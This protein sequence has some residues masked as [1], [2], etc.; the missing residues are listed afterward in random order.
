MFTRIIAYSFHRPMIWVLIGKGFVEF[1]S[2][3]RLVIFINKFWCINI[4]F[5]HINFGFK[6]FFN[7]LINNNNLVIFFPIVCAV[8][9]FGTICVKVTNSFVIKPIQFLR[10]ELRMWPKIELLLCDIF[11]E[12]IST[13]DFFG[14]FHYRFNAIHILHC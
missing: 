2:K 8:Y 5:H 7:S 13:K 6:N 1:A 14:K 9:C 10:L 12:I 4:I 3:R 11:V